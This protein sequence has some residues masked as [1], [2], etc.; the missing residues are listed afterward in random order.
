VN[1]A[2]KEIGMLMAKKELALAEAKKLE[3]AQHKTS[4]QQLNQ[5]LAE[6]EKNCKMIL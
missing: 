5:Q 1:A 2:S 4:L 6:T 3:V